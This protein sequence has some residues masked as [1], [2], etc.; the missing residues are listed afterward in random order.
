MLVFHT[1]LLLTIWLTSS[2]LIQNHG[3][4]QKVNEI[5]TTRSR[6]LLTFVIDS[7]PYEQLITKLDDDFENARKR[8]LPYTCWIDLINRVF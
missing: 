5:T 6:W 3:V 1:L 2:L 8:S 4:F 7:E